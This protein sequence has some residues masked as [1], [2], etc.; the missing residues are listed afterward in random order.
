MVRA[1]RQVEDR[2]AT[3]DQFDLEAAVW[4]KPRE[5]MKTAK[6]HWLPLSRQALG[7]LAEARKAT[8][9]ALVFP[10]QRPGAMVDHAVMTQ[11]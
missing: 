9:G 1:S 10:G 2:R 4:V 3:W 8:R 6:A 5:S 7:V 11:A